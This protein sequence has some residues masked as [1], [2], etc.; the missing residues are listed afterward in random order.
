MNGARTPAPQL[1]LQHGNNLRRK[2]SI[3]L[4]AMLRTGKQ[5]AVNGNRADT[6]EGGRTHSEIAGD[7]RKSTWRGRTRLRFKSRDETRITKLRAPRTRRFRG[8]GRRATQ[9]SNQRRERRLE[10]ETRNPDVSGKRTHRTGVREGYLGFERRAHLIQEP[11]PNLVPKVQ[12][13]LIQR[14]TVVLQHR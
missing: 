4:T 13:A 3:N 11:R 10:R 12:E 14:R 7:I 2:P 9:R 5:K 6:P 8:T 1:G